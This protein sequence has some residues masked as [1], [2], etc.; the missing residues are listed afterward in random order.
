MKK[1]IVYRTIDQKQ[2]VTPEALDTFLIKQAGGGYTEEQTARAMAKKAD[3][4]KN[5]GGWL[6]A[7]LTL[8]IVEA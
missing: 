8:E 3:L 6:S 2:E 1:L 4:Y 5:N 7:N